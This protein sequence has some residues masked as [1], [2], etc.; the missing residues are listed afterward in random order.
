METLPR[1]CTAILCLLFL[2]AFFSG[3]EMALTETS[4]VRLKSLAEKYAFLKKT[5]EW[6]N[7]DRSKVL[8]AIL[9]GNNLVNVAASTVATAIAVTLWHARGV[10]YAVVVMTVMI[11]I[12]G[13]VLPK[14]LALARGETVLIFSLLPIRFFAWTATPLIWMMQFIASATGKLTGLDL[15]LK[16]TF[17]T[18]EEI[19]Q[20][21]KIGEASGA[22]EKAERQMID[23]VI[24]LDEIRVS[25]IMVPRTEMH[26]IESCRTVDEALHFIQEMGDSRVP[27]YTDTPDHIDGVV[28]V[29]DLLSAFS[30]G[31]KS[32]AVTK[33]MRKPLF[34]PETMFVPKLFKIMQ[35]M[36]MH[37]ALV[38]D[39]YG[40]TA[41][42]VTMEDLLEEIVGEIQDEYDRDEPM[43][44]SLPDGT[45]KV[46]S[47]ISLED[48]NEALHSDFKCEDVDTL[49]GF[50]LDRFGNFPRQGD[51]ITL[52]GWIFTVTS[53][54]EH[55]IVEVTVKKADKNAQ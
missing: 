6:V 44:Q 53:M 10:A 34:V 47:G 16:D 27:V 33:V 8:S 21:V 28:L 38:V 24:S 7:V 3:A 30:Q 48:L 20:V 36:R 37:M 26:L 4:A 40:G 50:L 35:N 32:E 41:G 11:I 39:E 13:E 17:V 15:S 19:G 18:K 9:I 42:L 23:G 31:K 1:L 49:G 12:F 54:A 46:L 22:I 55:H 51:C 5:V 29:K 2:S 25:E 45:W 14:C 52:N 43:I